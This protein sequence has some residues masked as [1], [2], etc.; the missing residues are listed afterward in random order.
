MDE[1]GCICVGEWNDGGVCDWCVLCE[2]SIM[3]KRESVLECL[4]VLGV[5]RGI[6]SSRFLLF[7]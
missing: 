4:C 3:A 7:T 1:G 5:G 6:L 2:G